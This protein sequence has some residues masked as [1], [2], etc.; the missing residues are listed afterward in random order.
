MEREQTDKP[1]ET[2][3]NQKQEPKK[4]KDYSKGKIYGITDVETR[5]TYIGST[6]TSLSE[7]MSKHKLH[8]ECS[9]KIIIEKDN[10][11]YYVIEY[12]PCKTK[13][14]L[15]QREEWHRKRCQNC[16]NMVRAFITE[17]ER[18]QYKAEWF[19]KRYE[20]SYSYPLQQLFMTEI[21]LIEKDEHKKEMKKQ[22]DNT[23]RQKHSAKIAE[24]KAN[25]FQ[26]HKEEIYAYRKQ[27]LEQDEEAKQKNREYQA[28]WMRNKRAT[29]TD[30]QRKA[31]SQKAIERNNK[32]KEAIQARRAEKIVCECGQ[33]ITRGSKRLHTQSKRHKE[34]LENLKST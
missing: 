9:S 32:N 12:Y 1:K 6:I 2:L 10:Y 18:K 22:H 29:Y 24:W 25:Y 17:D 5:E 20:I 8:S 3:K 34:Y 15:R 30:E 23:Y 19:K 27:R 4:P 31:D 14:Q 16:V 11:E 28:E 33:E 26:E 13:E 7:R 21:E